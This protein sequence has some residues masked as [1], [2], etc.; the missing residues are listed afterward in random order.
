M[1]MFKTA[2][3]HNCDEHTVD[4]VGFHYTRDDLI[5]WQEAAQIVTERNASSLPFPDYRCAF[6]DEDDEPVNFRADAC[7]VHVFRDF[8]RFYGYE[9]H[10]ITEREWYTDRIYLKDLW[11]AFKD[12]GEEV[13][14]ASDEEA[15]PAPEEAA[16]Q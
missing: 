8:I 10:S 16:K 9:K 6:F 15:S 14:S 5:Q 2:P 7:S 12:E 3:I 4:H 11:D 13:P 1:P